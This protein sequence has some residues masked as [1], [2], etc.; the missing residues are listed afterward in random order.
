VSFRFRVLALTLLIA[1]TATAAT[2]WLTLRQ[3]SGQLTDSVT[4]A[5]RDVLRIS[6]ELGRYGRDHAGWAG[7]SGTVRAIARR[8]GLRVRV[9]TVSGALVADSDLL[10]GRPA[11]PVV[12]P[13]TL[14]DPRPTLRLL[15]GSSEGRTLDTVWS[16][17][18]RYV[19]A[20]GYARCL[21]A[22][23]KD[24]RA[25]PGPAGIPTY[26]PVDGGSPA[27]RRC[28]GVADRTT[29][30][31][32]DSKDFK[33]S[34]QGCLHGDSDALGSCLTHWFATRVAP[35]SPASV[36]VYVGARG[37]ARVGVG[38]GPTALAAGIVALAAIVA[39]VLLSRRVL[40]PVRALTAAARRLGDGA[41]AVPVPVSGR[42]EI[43]QLGRVFN[44]MAESL[45]AS[46]RRQRQ[47]IADIAHEL[48]TP[49]A[50]LRGYLEALADGVLPPSPELFA[51]LH[52]EAVLQQRIVDDLQVLALAESGALTYHE[53]PV[54]LGE[55]AEACRTAHAANAE[56]AGVALTVERD[57]PA[58]V[59]GDP[60]RLR[61]AVGNLLRN[62]LAATPAGGRIALTVAAREGRAR[63][64]VADTGTG[65]APADLP[66]LFDR[67]WRADQARGG[68]RSGLGLSIARQLVTDHGGTL[69]VA[70]TPGMGSTF[71]IDL[72]LLP[73]A[74]PGPS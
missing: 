69:A 1:V 35:Y 48:R 66:H 63:L 32:A 23:G 22:A 55:L 40:R 25:T 44:R 72:P 74:G 42:D 17:Y 60:G 39:A 14:A 31:P 67:F 34:L 11:R 3:A 50:N 6:D 12:G 15:P 36:Q 19:R 53:E 7:V 73:P 10:A 21:Q 61:Q 59:S 64:D 52:D 9:E 51:S 56:A 62:A 20:T 27:A 54:D 33:R 28:Q 18:R 5:N 43:A 45:A 24:V 58:M 57:G 65:I 2:A 70:S 26:H 71:T 8:T 68:A 16:S 47:Q 37:D 46:E 30:S 4:A 29:A 38:A 49:L 13:A 41:D